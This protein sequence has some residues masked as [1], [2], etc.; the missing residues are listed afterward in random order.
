MG[1]RRATICR[2]T[3]ITRYAPVGLA[4][5]RSVF[6]AR[7]LSALAPVGG[8]GQ[9]PARF[10]VHRCRGPSRMWSS[11]G[12]PWRSAVAPCHSVRLPIALIFNG[13]PSLSPSLSLNGVVPHPHRQGVAGRRDVH[14]R[15]AS[16]AVRTF[17]GGR[18]R[19]AWHTCESTLLGHSP[20]HTATRVKSRGTCTRNPGPRFSLPV[21]P[22]STSSGS[23]P[24]RTSTES[25]PSR[26]IA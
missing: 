18:T 13:V 15:R 5:T 23:P 14:A 20:Q 6:D 24:T 2:R 8:H 11:N 26:G 9:A 7:R 25:F 21:L 22:F 17:W 10:N 16:G 1:R 12:S 19:N 4:P 3:I